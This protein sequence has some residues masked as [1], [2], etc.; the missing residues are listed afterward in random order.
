MHFI[1]LFDVF[2][3]HYQQT[4]A[5]FLQKRHLWAKILT[6]NNRLFRENLGK[7]STIRLETF[8]IYCKTHL[9]FLRY[10]QHSLLSVFQS[11]IDFLWTRKTNSNVVEK[12]F[13]KIYRKNKKSKEKVVYFFYM[14]NRNLIN[15]QKSTQFNG[16]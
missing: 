9:T 7:A 14:N 5:F 2:F 8:L 3:L 15:I 11:V 10:F 6:L 1:N 13:K 4:K 12:Y 16:T